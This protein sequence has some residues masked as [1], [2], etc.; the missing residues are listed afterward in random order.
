MEVEVNDTHVSGMDA[1]ESEQRQQ[2]GI[3]VQNVEY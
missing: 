1:P 3:D 2:P